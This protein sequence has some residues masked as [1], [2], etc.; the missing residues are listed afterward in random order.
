MSGSFIKDISDSVVFRMPQGAHCPDSIL[1]AHWWLVQ[2]IAVER[3]VIA[4]RMDCRHIMILR[5][6]EG[7][8]PR[9]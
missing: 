4:A 8:V 7:G 3:F 1:Q 2:R 9:Y 6:E 5:R